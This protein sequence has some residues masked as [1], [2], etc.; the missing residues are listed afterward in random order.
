MT[1]SSTLLSGCMVIV[2]V[3]CSSEMTQLILYKF[4]DWVDNRERGDEVSDVP[5]RVGDQIDR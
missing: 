3:G 4:Q 1:Y 2:T 5:A